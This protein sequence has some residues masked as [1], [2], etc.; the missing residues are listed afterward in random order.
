[1]PHRRKGQKRRTITPVQRAQWA[2]ER[3]ALEGSL[4]TQEGEFEGAIVM[5]HIRG[6]QYLV[7]LKSGQEVFAAHKKQKD[8]RNGL[9]FDGWQLWEARE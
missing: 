9:S 4:I 3:K 7:Q 1:M 2:R 5:E 8:Q 6:S